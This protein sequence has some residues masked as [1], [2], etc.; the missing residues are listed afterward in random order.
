MTTHM[1]LTTLAAFVALALVTALPASAQGAGEIQIGSLPT[2][3]D[4][5]GNYV[6]TDGIR[7]NASRPV[8]ITIRARGVTLD[9]NGQEIMG[10]GGKFGMGVLVE[11]AQ[12]VEVRNGS[13]A[14]LAFGV[15]VQNSRNVTLRNLRIRGQ[16]LPVVELPPETGIMVAQSRN[17]VIEDNAIY[18]T[19]L[20]I[21]MRGGQSWGNRVANNTITAGTNGVLGICYNPTGS[22]PEAPRGDLVE[23]NLVSGFNLGL[24]MNTTAGYNVI[25]NNTFAYRGQAM[26]LRNDTNLVE[27]NVSIQLP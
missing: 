22:D 14:Y 27:N 13:L 26:E 17:V 9:L 15:V 11:G 3:I 5:P 25:R 16:G 4:Q 23:Y 1:K 12:G 7:L 20:G 10:P 18:N 21:F 8:G 2:T 19:G 6:L 24:Q